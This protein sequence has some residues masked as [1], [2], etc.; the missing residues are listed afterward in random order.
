MAE[1]EIVANNSSSDEEAAVNLTRNHVYSRG[2]SGLF[3]ERKSFALP[4]ATKEVVEK[5]LYEQLSK[6]HEVDAVFITV[7]DQIVHIY[8][9]T[10][11]FDSGTTSRVTDAEDRIE[12]EF[13]DVRFEFHTRVHQGR[14]PKLAAPFY[15]QPLFIR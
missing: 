11:E 15:S 5:S 7:E 10:R 8:S 6:I 13:L 9:I 12:A 14:D 4:N 3:D 1:T 2:P